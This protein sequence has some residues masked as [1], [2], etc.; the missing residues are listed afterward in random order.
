MWS[1]GWHALPSA[2]L[3]ALLTGWPVTRDPWRKYGVPAKFRRGGAKVMTAMVFI[4]LL[5]VVDVIVMTG[6]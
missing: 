5:L 3:Q 2:L 1:I 4:T 6:A